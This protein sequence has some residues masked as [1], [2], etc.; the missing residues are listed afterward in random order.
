MRWPLGRR[1]AT[2]ANLGGCPRTRR[3]SGSESAFRSR[4]VEAP[5]AVLRAPSLVQSARRLH[6]SIRE[7]RL[8][9]SKCRKACGRE[10]FFRERE[11]IPLRYQKPVPGQLISRPAQRRQ[12]TPSWWIPLRRCRRMPGTAFPDIRDGGSRLDRSRAPPQLRAHHHCA[13][14]S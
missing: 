6:C 14:P 5:G 4:S 3:E 1:A 12:G 7:A 2:C 8:R 13:G 10:S 11:S 9:G